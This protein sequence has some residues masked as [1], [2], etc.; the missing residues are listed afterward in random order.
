MS[1]AVY[2]GNFEYEAR[3]SE[4]ERLFDRYGRISRV[5]MKT[6][7]AFVYMDDERDGDDAIRALDGM[8]FGR[9]RRRLRVEWARGEGPVK[10]REVERRNSR[11]SK[12]LFVVNFDP[13]NTRTR[14]L[15]RHFEPYGKLVR[16]QIRKNFAFVQYET[17]EEA[18]KAVKETDGSSVDGRQ[19]TVEFAAREDSFDDDRPARR[20]SPDYGRR[21][22]PDYGRGRGR[23]SPD[24]GRYGRCV[25]LRTLVTLSGTIFL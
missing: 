3:Q 13:I 12:T 18:E 8:E 1:R 10:Q 15:E 7:F 2:C 19:I 6:G 16:V 25:K 22:S 20:G 21:G 17:I 9:Q 23:G 24:Y 5:D 4:I 11:P 14:D